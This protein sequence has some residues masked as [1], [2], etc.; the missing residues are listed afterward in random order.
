[1]R[2]QRISAAVPIA[3]GL[4]LDTD[5]RLKPA[6]R[7]EVARNCR[8][9]KTGALEKR[10]GFTR[11]G[12]TIAD[13]LGLLN[14][15]TNGP[16]RA[17]GATDR[18][19]LV[20][21]H[22]NLYGYLP[23]A[24]Q[25]VERG[26]V[27]PVK[28]KTR[29]VFGGH[30]QFQTGDVGRTSNYIVRAGSRVQSRSV[31]TDSS[32]EVEVTDFDDVTLFSQVTV[33]SAA[34]AAIPRGP[35][36]VGMT[37]S[38]HVIYGVGGSTTP[39]L[40][41]RAIFTDASLDVGTPVSL[42][43]DLYLDAGVG[44]VCRTW[45]ACAASGTE[46]FVAW[47]DDSSRDIILSL[48]NEAGSQTQASTLSAGPYV[49]VA[50]AN[51]SGAN[52]YVLAVRDTGAGVLALELWARRRT[53]LAAVWGP[54]AIPYTAVSAAEIIENLGIAEGV[55]IA[56]ATRI[57]YTFTVWKDTQTNNG[58]NA[59]CTL[60]LGST[61]TSGAGLD[62]M[63]PSTNALGMSYPFWYRNRCYMHAIP[64]Y[65]YLGFTTAHLI[66]TAIGYSDRNPKLAA[67]FDV[68]STITGSRFGFIGSNNSVMVMP[69][70]DEF[71]FMACN[72]TMARTEI[73]LEPRTA[74]D[75]ISVQF[76]QSPMVTACLPG[77]ALVSGGALFW[78]DGQKTFELGFSAPPI[79]DS[80]TIEV[81]AGL[82]PDGDYVLQNIWQFYDGSGNL[83][84]SLPTP[85]FEITLPGSVPSKADILVQWRTLPFSHRPPGDMNA[86]FYRTGT[87][88]GPD[89]ILRRGGFANT[90]VPNRV[91]ASFS[92]PFTHLNTNNTISLY[93]VGGVFE[94]VMPEGAQ[95]VHVAKER[96]CLGQF[97]RGSRVQWSNPI[98][99]QA[100][101]E[102][103]LAPEFIEVVGRVVANG[104]EIMG[105]SA[106]RDVWVI[107]CERS[108][109]LVGG[110][111]PDNKGLGDDFSRLVSVPAD[112]GC[113]EPRSVVS[114]PE[115][116]I[117]RSKRGFV[118]LNEK[119]QLKPISE[120]VKSVLDTYP[121][122]TSAVVCPDQMQ[123]RF[124]IDD[125]EIGIVLVYDYRIDEWFE[126]I[127][128]TPATPPT[129]GFTQPRFLG[130]VLYNDEYYVLRDNGQVWKEDSTTYWDDEDVYIPMQLQTGW[131]QPGGLDT[132]HLLAAFAPLASRFDH[133][134]L[135]IN[136]Y[137]DYN[138]T[139][140]VDSWPISGDQINALADP[141]KLEE[142]VFKPRRG[143]KAR[144]F[145]FAIG[146]SESSSPATTTGRGY[147]IA[148]IV[149]HIVVRGGYPK[150]GGSARV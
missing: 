1:M 35:V 111:G 2:S 64:W 98:S 100:V 48:Y 26:F 27:S 144:A 106:L 141:T 148:A 116:I 41:R 6:D 83:H 138:L 67:S 122:T 136:L 29:S 126:W 76:D 86:E 5:P 81:A 90:V 120:A 44:G 19:L 22:C 75:E 40:L 110:F 79:I 14:L 46:A 132:W 69:S 115:G 18:E 39:G 96:V 108:I 78:Y 72:V 134:D 30:G 139:T 68:S 11:Q 54:I 9:T 74:Y 131:I 84:R 82:I 17:I 101:G 94:N 91:G 133:H 28:G 143:R 103:Q 56:G 146:D 43:T 16:V 31:G 3:R 97:F 65:R 102:T 34:T 130:A 71:R 55:N 49:R 85:A 95:I 77:C 7:L 45:S 150:T 147:S 137:T 53:D 21:G 99:T 129:P 93:T 37:N 127:V 57:A 50:V 13:S 128:R 121:N 135:T 107:M 73:D 88:S 23:D 89:S 10:Y 47:V 24:N 80:S 42:S 59:Q 66:D 118:L 8:A 112:F 36:C 25:W 61:N 109:Y 4:G 87:T 52:V 51:G 38:V 92:D 142:L 70:G 104:D 105:I 149:P 140:V 117:Y 63:T 15:S 33:E 113:I 145:S 119:F 125:G 20:V 58:V 124:T 62:T 114:T 123:V 32:V 12:I 60:Y